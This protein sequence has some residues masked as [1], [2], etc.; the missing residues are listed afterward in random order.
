MAKKMLYEHKAKKYLLVFIVL[1]LTVIAYSNSLNNYFFID[2]FIH[3][4]RSRPSEMNKL[5]TSWELTSEDMKQSWWVSPDMRVTYFRPMV[6]LSFYLDRHLWGSN[7]FGFHISNLLM[8]LITAILVFVIANKLT[9]N[10]S[11]SFLSMSVFL[12]HPVHASA[13]QW[14]SGR[15]SIIMTL[16]YIFAFYCYLR[17]SDCRERKFLWSSLLM[18]FFSLSLLAKE[19]AITLPILLITFEIYFIRKTKRAYKLIGLIIGVLLI[20]LSIRFLFVPFSIIPD[21][22]F[23]QVEISSLPILALRLILYLFSCFLLLPIL[24]FHNLFVWSNYPVLLIIG[25]L[26]L[27]IIFLAVRKSLKNK[28]MLYFTFWFFF[29][30]IL[31]L[32]FMMGQRLAYLPSVGF[33]II[34]GML[35]SHWMEYSTRKLRMV[36]KC[37]F[38]FSLITFAFIIFVQGLILTDS[39]KYQHTFNVELSKIM[40]LY[41][42]R[43]NIY[44]LNSWM[45]ASFWLNYSQKYYSDHYNC[46]IKILFMDPK[47]LPNSFSNKLY[48]PLLKLVYHKQEIANIYHI[49]KTDSN[50]LL[51]K[52][53]NEGFFDG[54]IN[55]FFFLGKYAFY[56]DQIINCKSFDVRIDEML[57]QSVRSIEF[58]FDL[59]LSSNENLFI[60]Y[61]DGQPTVINMDR[62][63]KLEI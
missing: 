57:N 15:T 31:I 16:F 10:F 26:L 48:Y 1:A 58:T 40:K 8:H 29:T 28:L 53:E 2:D 14:I 60:I 45:P 49:R 59:P 5:L 23:A 46:N 27:T 52:S 62:I 50:K 33:S 51:L 56:Q 55:Q 25:S 63:E 30:L 11:I 24:P 34:S 32:P 9:S 35:I 39:A 47:V 18:L 43:K 44:L 4:D 20:Y 17:Y 41:P 3:L 38:A 19:A 61:S 37:I 36:K 22:Y 7:P 12:L 13:V 54:Q 42:N 21:P 6:S